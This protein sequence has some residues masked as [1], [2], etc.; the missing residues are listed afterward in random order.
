L[1]YGQT[2]GGALSNPKTLRARSTSDRTGQPYM[3]RFGG[4]S[5]ML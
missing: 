4:K 2:A 5:K 3:A 1:G